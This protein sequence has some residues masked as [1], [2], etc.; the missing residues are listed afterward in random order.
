MNS[1]F[2]YYATYCAAVLAGY[3]HD[4]ALAIAYSDCFV[5]S[6]SRTMLS[7]LKAPPSAATTQLNLELMDAR[8]DI[9]GLQDITRIWSSFHFLPFDLY[10][11]PKKRCSRRYK[12]KFRLICNPNGELVKS[13]VMLAK[14]KTPQAVG[15]AMHVLSDTWA[16]RY[17]AGTPSL[18]INNPYK[19]FYE[20][21]PGENGFSERKINF[22]HSASAPDDLD[23]SVYTS[24]L[25]SSSENSIMNLGHGR[26]GHLPDYCFIRYRFLPA[27]GNYEEITKDNPTDFKNAFCQMIYAMKFL[28]GEFEE[29]ELD[30]YDRNAVSGFEDDIDGILR[31]RQPDSSEDWKKLA[32]RLSGGI[33]EPYSAEKYQEEYR[34]AERDNKDNT[35]LGKFILAALAQKGMVTNKIYE[36]GSKLAGRSIDHGKKARKMLANEEV[37]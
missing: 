11:E 3:S 34:A 28:R 6:C 12:A 5:D 15:V 13:T 4:D 37:K 14:N 1:D 20:L 22:R 21:I 10:A 8:T 31:R 36:S 25:Y 9:S 19:T 7:K 27:W 26:A 32:K 35:F 16:H 30:K 23:K 17:F 2:H 33:P 18:V 24:S 29:F